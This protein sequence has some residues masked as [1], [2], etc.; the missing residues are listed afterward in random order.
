MTF[1]VVIVVVG[2]RWAAGQECISHSTGHLECTGSE[3]KDGK[4]SVSFSELQSY[5]GKCLCMTAGV[6]GQ[7]GQAGWR[8]LKGHCH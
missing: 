6:R 8:L 4:Y 1:N 2:A 3:T 7:T 5:G